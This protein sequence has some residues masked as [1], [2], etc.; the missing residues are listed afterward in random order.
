MQVRSWYGLS[1][2][3]S[4]ENELWHLVKVGRVSLPH[5]PLVNL[6]LRRGQPRADRLHLSY[7]HE[8]GHLQTLPL[9]VLHL[10]LLIW[11][12]RWQFANPGRFKW[13][14]AL[15]VAHQAS[16]ELFSETY[17]IAHEGPAYQAVYQR[18]PNRLALLFWIGMGG[19]AAGLSGWVMGANRGTDRRTGDSQK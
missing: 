15:V 2:T 19:L 3:I 13:L 10:L 18:S 17:V 16:W 8:F 14:I 11:L 12:G 6:V 9:A 4:V 1:G 5:P 7:L